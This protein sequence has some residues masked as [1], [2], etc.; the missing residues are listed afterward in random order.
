MSM[1]PIEIPI[2]VRFDDFDKKSIKIL[3]EIIEA[4]GCE[5]VISSDWRRHADLDDMG[6]YYDMQGII[7]KPIAYTPNLGDCTNYDD[8]FE[9]VR[10]WD[11]QQ[12]RSLEIKQ[13]LL[14]NPDVTHW[15]AIDDLNMGKTG[16]YYGQDFT[17]DWGLDNF[18]LTPTGSKGIKDDG[19][20]EK[21]INFLI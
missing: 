15:V 12:T 21:V 14:N 2:D 16:M 1:S 7:K 3:N 13:Y 20:K 19:I 18:V 9:W 17:H 6:K 11:S 4:T 8:T 10:Q 5:I